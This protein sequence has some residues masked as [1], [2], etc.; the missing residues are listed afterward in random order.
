MAKLGQSALIW[1]FDGKFSER[2]VSVKISREDTCQR[3]S[4]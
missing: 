1:H 4:G 3:P 2:Q